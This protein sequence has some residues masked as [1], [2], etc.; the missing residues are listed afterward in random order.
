MA[1][2]SEGCAGFLPASL[3]LSSEPA[4]T[5][6]PGLRMV[7]VSSHLLLSI[8]LFPSPGLWLFF[9]VSS[10]GACVR[11]PDLP[12]FL[13]SALSPPDSWTWADSHRAIQ[14][15]LCPSI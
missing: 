4:Q 3:L 6:S 2:L 1:H 8:C 5:Y 11:L 10:N 14:G 12:A 15:L 7:G 13:F 9:S